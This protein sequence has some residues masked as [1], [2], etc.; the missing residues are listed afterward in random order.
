MTSP[1][2]LLAPDGVARRL[3]DGG[4]GQRSP[5]CAV[6]SRRAGRPRRRVLA[7]ACAAL[8]LAPAAHGATT[9]DVLVTGQHPGSACTA[10]TPARPVD[11]ACLN[12]ALKA[13]VK[14]GRPAPPAVDAATAQANTPSK[15]GTFSHAATAQRMGQNF[16]HSAQP[17]RPPAPTYANP[18]RGTPPR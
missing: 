4:A 9:P 17:Y 6:P 14:A 2:P 3:F 10:S 5:L 18:V 8:V 11:Y 12:Q 16:G 15:V 1:L 13:A 7:T